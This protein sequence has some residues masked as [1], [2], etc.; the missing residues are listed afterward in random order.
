MR[1]EL[2][3]AADRRVVAGVFRLADEKAPD[4]FLA[5]AERIV[6]ER[7]DAVVVHAGGGPCED[8]VRRHLDA[9]PHRD[10]IHLL[11][12]RH[13]VPTIMAAADVLLLCSTHEGT[14]NVLIE[15]QHLG[16]PVVSTDAGG[17]AETFEHGRT[18]LLC[19]V[20]DVDALAESTLRLLRDEPLRRA[21][22]EAAPA[23]ARER[24]ALDR[25]V[26]TTLA[27]YA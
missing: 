12:R 5:V 8:D 23:L 19:A 9:S 24:F 18:G 14:P 4:V 10:R 22:A 21:M 27:C 16:C 3:I 6:A 2:A 20:G 11:G 25:M 7:P 15:A 26:E 17:A 1:S 13:D